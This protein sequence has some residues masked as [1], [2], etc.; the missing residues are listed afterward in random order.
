MVKKQKSFFDKLIQVMTHSVDRSPNNLSH[1]DVILAGG[2]LSWMMTRN[3]TKVTHGHKMIYY[4]PPT[5]PIQTTALRIPYESRA[6]DEGKYNMMYSELLD[7]SMGMNTALKIKQILPEESAVLMSNG[8]KLTY[9]SLI[10]NSAL[11]DT[12]EAIPGLVEGLNNGANRVFST[13]PKMSNQLFYSFVS[14]FEHGEAVI[15]IPEFPFQS[16][17][18][19]MN[20]LYALSTWEMNERFGISSPKWHLTI[21]NANDRFASQCDVLDKYIRDRLASHSKVSVHFNT[22]LKSINNKDSTLT[23]E[24]QD[25]QTR[26]M[27]FRRL[28]CHVPTKTDSMLV[29]SGLLDAADMKVK[30]NPATLAHEKFENVFVYGENIDVKVQP[31]LE[32]SLTQASVARHNALEYIEGRSAKAEYNG[33]TFIPIF[34]G[35]HNAALYS[36]DWR[37]GPSIKE[38]LLDGWFNYKWA[39]GSYAK[40]VRKAF[41]S[42]SA[43]PM[44]RK[45]PK[46]AKGDQVRQVAP[47]EHHH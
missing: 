27:E 5:M 37:K 9:G 31:S 29:G 26:N 22:K 30:V 35:V 39:V 18:E 43:A 40:K 11:R 8:Q 28:Y 4:D 21:I 34:H 14:L 32:A 7:P 16:E 2:V 46:F 20:I 1:Y 36:S 47:S 33:R 42:K 19:H 13:L 38:G 10:Y 12:P 45:A 15:Y 41:I 17:I 6:V 24:G 44:T 25:G 23:L 3:L